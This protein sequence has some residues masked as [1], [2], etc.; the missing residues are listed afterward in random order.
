MDEHMT[1]QKVLVTPENIDEMTEFCGWPVRVGDAIPIN[2]EC[3]W[4][5]MRHS[6]PAILETS[7]Q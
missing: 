7:V 4:F 1:Y 6:T 5:K 2:V 3:E